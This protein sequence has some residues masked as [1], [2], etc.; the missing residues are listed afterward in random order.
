M[1]I[2][3]KKTLIIITS[4]VI[5]TIITVHYMLTN[6]NQNIIAD[7]AD[8]KILDTIDSQYSTIME[9]IKI[10]EFSKDG[11]LTRTTNAMSM[12]HNEKKDIIFAKEVEMH[13]LDRSDAPYVVNADSATMTKNFDKITL[14]ENVNIIQ[15]GEK[16]NIQIIGSSIT[17]YP[18]TN[19]AETDE[20]VTIIHQNTLTLRSKGMTA[21]F[22][23]KIYTMDNNARGVYYEE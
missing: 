22:N 7:K 11:I 21:D 17:L 20:E 3:Y 14:I 12:K 13:I 9:N 4:I 1:L 10:K 19:Y 16:E 5:L 15:N 2:K 23:K 8:S 18:G 6:D